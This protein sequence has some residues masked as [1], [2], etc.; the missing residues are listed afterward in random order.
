MSSQDVNIREGSISF[1]ITEGKMKFNDNRFIPL[2]QLN[3][4]NG[5]IF[6]DKNM[7]NK[8]KFSHIYIG[9]GTTEVEHDVSSL[10]SDKSHMIAVTWSLKNREIIMYI[11]GKPVAKTG[12]DYKD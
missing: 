11:D 1:W 12:I 6:I 4:R 7:D 10:D 2:I 8:L 5:S 9:K 3:P